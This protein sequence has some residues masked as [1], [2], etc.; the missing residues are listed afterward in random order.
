[1]T[2]KFWPSFL[3][4][5]RF[6]EDYDAG[7][8]AYLLTVAACYY[9]QNPVRVLAPLFFA[10][11]AG[12]VFG[13][14]FTRQGFN[15]NWWQNKSVMGSFAVL[16]FAFLSL[17]TADPRRRALVAILCALAEAFGGK[18]YDNLAIAAVVIGDWALLKA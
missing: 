4:T 12:A 9:A 8:T 7:I 6:G 10:D 14:F 16:V 1:M 2:W 11:P 3:P 15:R 13:K 17:S 5:F 18:T